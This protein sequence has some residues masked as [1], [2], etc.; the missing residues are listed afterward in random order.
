M[1]KVLHLIHTPRHSGA[2]TLVRDLCLAHGRKGIECAVAAFAPARAEY[3]ADA[4]QL[5]QAGTKLYFPLSVLAKA[6]RI[7][8]FREVYADFVP[9]AVFAHSVLPSFYGRLALPLLSRRKPLFTT[10]L[11]AASNDDFKGT[12]FTILEW[13]TKWRSD[14]IV[15][16]SQQG[17]DNYIRRFGKRPPVTVI[18][19]GI[20]VEQF[21]SVD[22]AAA[23]TRLGLSEGRR[24]I[25]Q[26]GRLCRVKQ[27]H[28]SILA[29]SAIASTEE[30]ELWLAGLTEQQEY[31]SLLHELV[32]KHGLEERVKFLGSRADVPE[33]LAAADLYLMP[34]LAESQGIALLEAIASGVPAV[35]SAIPA[36]DIYRGRDDIEVVDV[37]D[38]ENFSRAISKHRKRATERSDLERFS[39]KR[40]AESYLGLIYD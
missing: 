10:V 32:R 22:R 39:I 20:D 33:L 15:A 9:D 12:Y 26:V 24:M 8:H 27:Q 18:A 30:V 25:L 13:F 28:L 6:S 37:A 21:R 35:V 38:L 1:T 5:K 4:K 23:R 36:F 34:S 14:R 19:N 7:R 31:E 11:H 40:A 3:L 2:E 16:V 17:A 29:F